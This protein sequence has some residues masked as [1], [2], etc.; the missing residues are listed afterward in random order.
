MKLLKFTKENME[1][2]RKRNKIME[3]KEEYK[4]LSEED[5]RTKIEQ[6]FRER[7]K[8]VDIP[9]VTHYDNGLTSL[10]GKGY[11]LTMNTL[12]YTEMVK[13]VAEEY[14]NK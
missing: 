4:D 5:L 1:I 14:F 3:L 8:D 2:N 11:S 13:Q 7:M 10:V 12:R 6:H 9:T